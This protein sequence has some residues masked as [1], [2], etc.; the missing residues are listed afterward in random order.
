MPCLS[1]GSRHGLRFL[2]QH[3]PSGFA[4]LP[5]LHELWGTRPGPA[6]LDASGGGKPPAHSCGDRGWGQLLRHRQHVLS[7]FVRGDRRAR[8]EGLC[9]ARRDRGG[10]EDLHAVARRAQHAGPFAQGD[11]PVGGR[12]PAASRHGLHRSAADSPLRPEHA[13]RSDSGSPRSPGALGQGAAHRR[14][15]HA[16]LALHACP[17]RIGNERLGEVRLHA[18]PLQPHLP[19][20]RARND[21]AVHR[22]GR[23]DHAVEPARAGQAHPRLGRGNGTLQIR[24]LRQHALRGERGPRSC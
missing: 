2:R 16:C 21:A 13:D 4:H 18:E 22:S 12:Q 14:V 9:P 7:G 6:P 11:H 5:R 1:P 24:R 10:H 17:A 3:R 19:R 15:H 23:R 8:T 20:G